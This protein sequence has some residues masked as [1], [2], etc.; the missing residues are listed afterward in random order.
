V[1]FVTLPLLYNEF[2]SVVSSGTGV[3]IR[4]S[5]S[6]SRHGTPPQDET[7]QSPVTLNG[8][9]PSCGDR[10]Q[11]IGKRQLWQNSHGISVSDSY[12][13]TLTALPSRWLPS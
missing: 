1:N 8:S 5:Y 12:G 9:S 4:K 2:Q 7:W 6:Q 3:Q 13:K 10:D 11:D